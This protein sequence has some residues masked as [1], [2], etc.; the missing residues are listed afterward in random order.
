MVCTLYKDGFLLKTSLKYPGWT[1]TGITASLVILI[2]RTLRPSVEYPGGGG[3]GGGILPWRGNFT[4][5]GGGGGTVCPSAECP[6]GHS[7]RGDNPLSHTPGIYGCV[8]AA[9]T[10]CNPIRPGLP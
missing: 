9:C 1:F 2:G 4:L 5:G 8:H 10:N 7:A 6:G 3:G